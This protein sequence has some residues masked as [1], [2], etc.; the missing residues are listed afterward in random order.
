MI[1]RKLLNVIT[2]LIFKTIKVVTNYNLG[3]FSERCQFLAFDRSYIFN[4]E[5]WRLKVLKGLDDFFFF[6][7]GV[8]FQ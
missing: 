8:F 2:F 6:V 3:S 4:S 1:I 7:G 5:S